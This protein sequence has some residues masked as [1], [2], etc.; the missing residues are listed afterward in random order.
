[1]VAFFSRVRNERPLWSLTEEIVSLFPFRL[2]TYL[3]NSDQH[4]P[5]FHSAERRSD[6]SAVFLAASNSLDS[7]FRFI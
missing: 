6:S 7:L 3:L 1:M 2:F 4:L 5:S